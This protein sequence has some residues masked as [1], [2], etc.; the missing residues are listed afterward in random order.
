MDTK[1]ADPPAAAYP[2]WVMLNHHGFGRYYC[3]P[4]DAT[5]TVASCLSSAGKRIHVSFR[6]A[7]PPGNSTLFLDWPDV[8]DP[9]ELQTPEVIAAHGDSVLIQARDCTDLGSSASFEYF[10]YRAAGGGPP[11]MS[12]LP[13]C[14][15]QR[16]G[17]SPRTGSGRRLKAARKMGSTDTGLLRRGEDEFAVAQ[18]IMYEPAELCVL[19]SGSL[20]WETKRPSVIYAEGARGDEVNQSWETD[21]VVPIG[22]QFLCWV[23]YNRGLVLCDVFDDLEEPV[24]RCV[25]LPVERNQGQRHGY[26]E[27]GRTF[28]YARNI[29]TTAAGAVRFVSIDRRCCCGGLLESRCPRSRY[30]FTLTT[31]TLDMDS[32]TWS[33]DGVLHCDELWALP[34]YEG[35]QPYSSGE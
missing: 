24:L 9:E 31:W 2:S 22:D 17:G 32:M 4:A 28:K 20:E 35:L 19:R 33:I 15:L 16:G 25:P 23:D 21:A 1:P 10:V 26:H 30:S 3:F 11:S 8:R 12:L 14:Y 34:G 6:L 7:A 27:Y 13:P 5:N 29:G 18:L